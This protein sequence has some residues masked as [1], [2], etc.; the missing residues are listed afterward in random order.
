ME[1][2][3]VSKTHMT[4]AVCVGGLVLADNRYVRLLNPGNYNQ[5]T[6]TDFEVGEVWDLTFTNRV[7]VRG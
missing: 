5:P 6:D 7:A 2:L 4:N 1:V 3:I